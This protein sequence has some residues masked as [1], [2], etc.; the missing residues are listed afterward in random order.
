MPQKFEETDYQARQRLA[1][2]L[3]EAVEQFAR[4]KERFEEVRLEKDR[5]ITRLL[6]KLTF[7]CNGEE[8][9]YVTHD[10]RESPFCLCGKTKNP[11][12]TPDIIER[13][14]GRRKDIPHG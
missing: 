14:T 10:T 9:R 4:D 11:L 5:T 8:H 3:D 12:Y 6:A 13:L 2:E 7:Q 1:R